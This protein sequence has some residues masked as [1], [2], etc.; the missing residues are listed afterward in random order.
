[1]A[2]NGVIGAA[3]GSERQGVCRSAIEDEEYLALSFEEILNLFDGLL[4]PVVVP[5]ARCMSKVG[6]IE[7]GRNFRAGARVVV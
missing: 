5:V 6:L 2:Q 3:H 4:R 1:M 7:N